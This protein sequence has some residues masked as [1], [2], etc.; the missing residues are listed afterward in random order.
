MWIFGEILT[1]RQLLSAITSNFAFNSG[2]KRLAM[3]YF[4]KMSALKVKNT[5][6]LRILADLWLLQRL[7]KGRGSDNSRRCCGVQ[8]R[9]R[10]CSGA[11]TQHR[12]AE[13]NTSVRNAAYP[14]FFSRLPVRKRSFVAYVNFVYRRWFLRNSY[15]T[16]KNTFWSQSI[17]ISDPCLRQAVDYKFWVYFDFCKCW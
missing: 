3:R 6:P 1:H 5:Y 14:A 16:L 12:E 11:M 2:W 9:V 10:E 13:S 4:S 8:Y 17:C 7:L 15:R